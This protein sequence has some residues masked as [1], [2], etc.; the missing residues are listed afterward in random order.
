MT[1]EVRWTKLI[2]IKYFTQKQQN[3]HSFQVHMEHS[4]GKD[5]ILGHKARL[6][7]VKKIDIISSIFSDYNVISLEVNYKKKKTVKNTDTWRLNN[8]LLNNQWTTK[9]IKAEI[10]RYLE[11]KENKSIT[12]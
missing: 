4:P 10:Q 3:T 2:F 11:T 7:K 5:H 12:I 8:M 9:E 6:G 1:R